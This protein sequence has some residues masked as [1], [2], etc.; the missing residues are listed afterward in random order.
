MPAPTLPAALLHRPLGP[1]DAERWAEL[2]AAIEDADRRGEHYDAADC[3]EELADPALDLDRDSVL[4]LDGE[5]PVAYQVLHLRVGAGSRVLHTDAGVHPEH[6]RCGIGAVLLRL[7]RER[8]D[9]LDAELHVRVPETVPGAV[10]LVEGAGLVAVRW[11]SELER[12]LTAPVASAPVPAGLGLHPLGP[13][14]DAGRWDE[15]LRAA[16]NA[17][18]ADHWGSAPDDPEAWVHHRTG[19][20]GFHAGCSVAAADDAGRVAGLL[21][22]YEYE[23]DTARTGRRDLY[24]GTVATVREWRGRGLASALLAHA[25]AAARAEGF[26]SSSLTVDA[27]NPTGA[28]GVYRRAGYHLD[29]REITYRPAVARARALSAP[30]E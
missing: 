1:A 17:A 23:A 10:A 14:Y 15:P 22:G 29:R 25:L 19:C 2:L 7:A 9:E 16:R 28:L 20:R 27:Q 11:W 5:R 8:A 6:R 12:D 18:F 30:E 13:G 21:L 3:A 4:V 26:A 24:I